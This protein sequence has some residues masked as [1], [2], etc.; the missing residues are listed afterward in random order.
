VAL[1]VIRHL[2]KNEERSPINRGGGSVAFGAAARCVLLA[3]K[4]PDV[5]E[6]YVLASVK[7]NLARTPMSLAYRI[8]EAA[9]GNPR[10]EWCGPSLHTAETLLA[11]RSPKRHRGKALSDAE[12]VLQQELANGPR[13]AAEV[14]AAA[15]AKGISTRT[16]R[17][18][19]KNL[20]IVAKPTAFQGPSMW[21][22]P[23]TSDSTQGVLRLESAE[24]PSTP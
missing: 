5:P 2:N 8:V 14:E 18:G 3:A 24:S 19:R 1:L 20:G 6:Q 15:L 4:D 22:M 11:V 13:E 21:T 23:S 16:L 17:R 10:I 7:N 9:N 12:E